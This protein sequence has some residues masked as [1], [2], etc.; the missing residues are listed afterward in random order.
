MMM[1]QKKLINLMK[2][3]LIMFLI[4]IISKKKHEEAPLKSEKNLRKKHGFLE[5]SVH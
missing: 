5:P 1:S 4:Q 3:F 2:I